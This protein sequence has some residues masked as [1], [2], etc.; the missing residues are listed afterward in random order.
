MQGACTHR[1]LEFSGSIQQGF[2][3]RVFLTTG[4][5]LEIFENP[6][7][8]VSQ[9]GDPTP[10]LCEITPRTEQRLCRDGVR[11]Q[12][13]AGFLPSGSELST[14]RT[15]GA[16]N[17]RDWLSLVG[18]RTQWKCG[19]RFNDPVLQ[20]ERV[21]SSVAFDG[22]GNSPSDENRSDPFTG[23]FPQRTQ[24]SGRLRQ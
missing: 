24:D 22:L 23:S 12:S 11:I 19:R 7:D 16:E 8:R 1:N 14:D 9:I 2:F 15:Q 5:H 10:I 18:R 3:V 6:S 13:L 20:Q 21:S 17:P 4:W